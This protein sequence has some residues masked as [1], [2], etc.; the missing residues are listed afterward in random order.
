M[1]S[2]PPP[3]GNGTISRI[4][5]TGHANS[6]ASIDDDAHK[7]AAKRPAQTIRIGATDSES[8]GLLLVKERMI[9]ANYVAWK[10]IPP[11]PRRTIQNCI[12]ICNI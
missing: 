9:L 2:A 3:A 11:L 6:A 1:V 8:K 4:G 10:T 12:S 5:F 7:P